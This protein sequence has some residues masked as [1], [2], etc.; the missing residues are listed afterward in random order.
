M[1]NAVCAGNTKKTV[2]RSMYIFWTGSSANST[3]EQNAFCFS[4]FQFQGDFRLL[5]LVIHSF[6]N[7]HSSRC[8]IQ[9]KLFR[10]EDV[11][12]GKQQEKNISSRQ[13]RGIARRVG[14]CTQMEKKIKS[15]EQNFSVDIPKRMEWK[16]HPNQ[17]RSISAMDS[18]RCLTK[19][20]GG[21]E[22]R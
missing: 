9:M 2:S 13:A 7:F 16:L 6:G 17:T 4:D 22:R 15:C 1:V 14:S 11:E 18:I 3:Q 20:I 21:G 5:L 12:N 19:G 8:G 10:S